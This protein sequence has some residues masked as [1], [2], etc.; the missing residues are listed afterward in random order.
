MLAES[1]KREI[2]QRILEHGHQ[3]LTPERLHGILCACIPSRPAADEFLANLMHEQREWPRDRFLAEVWQFYEA[4][5]KPN[6]LESRETN[7]APLCMFRHFHVGHT[8]D[9]QFQEF[10]ANAFASLAFWKFP[11]CLQRPLLHGEGRVANVAALNDRYTLQVSAAEINSIWTEVRE[12][13]DCMLR[14]RD[15][16]LTVR[17]EENDPALPVSVA[18]QAA[19]VFARSHLAWA[20]CR[21]EAPVSSNAI[22]VLLDARIVGTCWW[23]ETEQCNCRS[24]ASTALAVMALGDWEMWCRRSIEGASGIKPLGEDQRRELICDDYASVLS[25][26]REA[27]RDALNALAE[28]ASA[29]GWPAYLDGTDLH[30]S[31]QL[32]ATSLAFYSLDRF[33]EEYQTQR[34]DNM[35][36]IGDWLKDAIHGYVVGKT[37]LFNHDDCGNGDD[38]VESVALA[39]TV[40]ARDLKPTGALWI[41]KALRWLLL[42]GPART[43]DGVAPEAV[44]RRDILAIYGII[45]VLRRDQETN[46]LDRLI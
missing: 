12:W 41:R 23:G 22:R 38:V 14:R 33:A 40:V 13:L 42:N 7:R 19:Y 5:L 31:P 44:Q 3:R 32:R 25:E 6:F 1:T 10:V 46:L 11:I 16:R 17:P 37:P 4:R 30:A 39:L 43:D 15:W 28:T 8:P 21:L 24:V 2:A 26:A 27:C 9:V 29:V 34:C 36:T 18:A 35:D 45:E 20:D